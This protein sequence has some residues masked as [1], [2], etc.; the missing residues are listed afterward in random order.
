MGKGK[1]N[2]GTATRRWINSLLLDHP[3]ALEYQ[4]QRDRA[5][6]GRERKKGRVGAEGVQRRLRERHRE[7]QRTNNHKGP[8]ESL[9]RLPPPALSLSLA[10]ILSLPPIA[11]ISRLMCGGEGRERGSRGRRE[12][13]ERETN[14][15]IQESSATKVSNLSSNVETF[16]SDSWMFLFRGSLLSDSS[17]CSWGLFGFFI[18]T[19]LFSLLPPLVA[20]LF[21]RTSVWRQETR[22]GEGKGKEEAKRIETPEERVG[23]G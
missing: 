10:P 21:N 17:L 19:F 16:V 13:R 11:T 1:R 20:K 22:E 4:C 2:P 23:E 5:G 12:R 3:P 18:F 15:N 9:G 8:H 7:G 14:D 6:G